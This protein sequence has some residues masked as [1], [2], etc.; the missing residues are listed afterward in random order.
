[1]QFERR[2]ELLRL[3]LNNIKKDSRQAKAV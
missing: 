2:R 1:M 3:I